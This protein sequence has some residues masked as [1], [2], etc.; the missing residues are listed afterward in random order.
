MVSF[1]EQASDISRLALAAQRLAAWN[2]DD[3]RALFRSIGDRLAHPAERR[4][5]A[6]AA[7]NAGE[8]HGWVRRLVGEHREN[9]PVAAFLEER[10]YAPVPFVADFAGY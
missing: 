2:R 1:I 5:I 8:E 4:I 7:L 9:A 6:L 10:H 3:A